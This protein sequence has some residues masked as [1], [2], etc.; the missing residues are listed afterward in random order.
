M[1]KYTLFINKEKSIIEVKKAT[2]AFRNVVF[3][4]DVWHYNNNYYV[5][6]NRK[7]LIAKATEIKEQWITEAKERLDALEQIKIV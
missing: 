4:E 7:A 3:S 2:I 1:A 6:T 5:S